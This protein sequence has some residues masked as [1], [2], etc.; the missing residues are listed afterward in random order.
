MW[1]IGVHIAD[2]SHYVKPH[3]ELD[4][5][6]FLRGT[7]VYLVDRTIPMLPEK[8]SNNVCSLR[9]N[10]DRLCFS[11]VFLMDEQ[12]RIHH[13]WFGKTIIHNNRRFTYEEVQKILETKKGDFVEE[14]FLLDKLAKKMREER[15]KKGSIIFDKVK[16][17][18]TLMK[19]VFQQ[20]CISKFSKMPIV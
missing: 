19:A 6:A 15:Y 12:A 16:S 14:L 5:E 13:Q 18:F 4:K 20:E 10:E 7:S 1:E 2:V 17:N 11:A 3:T 8:L 9:P